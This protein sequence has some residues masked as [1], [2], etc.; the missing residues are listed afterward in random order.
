MF[1]REIELF[2][3]RHNPTRVNEVITDNAKILSNQLYVL[4]EGNH[5]TFD[6]D[7]IKALQSL[8]NDLKRVLD[9]S[10]NL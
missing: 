7:T 5:V 6:E 9:K 10:P 3:I 2:D 8:E 1:F 4:V